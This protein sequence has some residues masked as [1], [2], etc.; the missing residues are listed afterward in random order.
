MIAIKSQIYPKGGEL[1]S[2]QFPSKLEDARTKKNPLLVGGG[3]SC[4]AS[5]LP[6]KE[7]IQSLSVVFSVDVKVAVD[8]DY[9]ADFFPFSDTDQS[10]IGKVH[11]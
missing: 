6:F 8:A 7:I 1:R 10:R 2:S 3:D 9:F 4:I 5:T 11:W